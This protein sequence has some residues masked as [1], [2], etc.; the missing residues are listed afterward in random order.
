MLESLLYKNSNVSDLKD[1]TLIW[2]NIIPT[3][4]DDSVNEIEV[5]ASV[6]EE[7]KF[8][9]AGLLLFLDVPLTYLV[10]HLIVNGLKAPTDY[11]ASTKVKLISPDVLT[12][13]HSAINKK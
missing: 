3:L 5:T 1:L 4:P 8:S 12:N 11:N 2:A 13:Y 7:F 6:A 9:F 10:P